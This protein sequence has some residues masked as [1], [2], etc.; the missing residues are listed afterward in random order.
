M[1]VMELDKELTRIVELRNSISALGGSSESHPDFGR[2][3][4]MEESFVEKY[5]LYLE[6]AL[7]DVHDEICPDDQIHPLTAYIASQYIDT[8]NKR[9][10]LKVFEVENDQGVGV[11]TDDYP[12]MDTKLVIIPNPCRIMLIVGEEEREELWRARD[13]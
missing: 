10:G 8:G 5:G 12:G 11:G 6:D 4:E 3:K 7:R 13:N 2:L 9:E 1:E